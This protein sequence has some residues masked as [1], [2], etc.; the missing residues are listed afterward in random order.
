MD[1]TPEIMFQTTRSGGKGGQNVN[2]VE[3][4]VIAHFDVAASAL[5]DERGKDCVFQKLG[6]RI[7]KEGRLAVKA[8]THRS[9]LENKAE[10][11]SRI[12]ELVADALKKKKFRVPTKPSRAAKAARTELKKQH[13]ERKTDRRK[14]R[15]SD[16]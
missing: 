9:Q 8:Q 4:A 14:F 15:A 3:T 2:K 6:H 1:L 10:A 13:S 16:F 5:L 11:A 7:N 12:N